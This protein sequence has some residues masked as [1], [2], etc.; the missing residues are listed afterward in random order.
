MTT[1]QELIEKHQRELAALELEER[2]RLILPEAFH[3]SA[4][5]CIHGGKR[6]HFSAKMWNDFRC[7]KKLSDALEIVRLFESQIVEC[8]H[9]KSGCISTW[10]DAIN[11]TKDD[12]NAVMD[13][14]HVV[15]ISVQG[16]KG[17]GPCVE[18]EF[19]ADIP[20]L[21]LV[22]FSCPVCDLWKLVPSVKANYNNHG[23]LSS[24]DIRWPIE[25][26]CT[27]S[28]RT[29]W[30]DKPSYRGSYYLADLPNFY[31]WAGQI[32]QQ[33]ETATV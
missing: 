16:G 22:E 23:D 28:F 10:P 20:E 30:S 31:S 15:E 25:S 32:N 4:L 7:E 9:W 5:I 19:W 8:G 17:F 26:R 29:W 2:A 3:E 33:K 24:C 18:V 13:G 1:K 21:G 12:E 14:S 11:T 6:K 27:D